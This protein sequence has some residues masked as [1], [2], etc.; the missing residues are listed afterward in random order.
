MTLAWFSQN[1]DII[2][3]DQIAEKLR[4]SADNVQ[5]L[6]DYNDACDVFTLVYAVQQFV[7]KHR[8]NCECCPVSQLSWI[9]ELSK[10]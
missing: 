8:K 9:Q 10:R 5:E 6:A 1:P 4:S 2:D 7:N 3:R